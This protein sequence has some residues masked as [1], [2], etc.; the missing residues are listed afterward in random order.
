MKKNMFTKLLFVLFFFLPQW[1]MAQN[2]EYWREGFEPTHPTSPCNLATVAPTTFQSF[3]FKGN[4]GEWYGAGVYSTTGTGCPAG[5]PHLRFRNLLSAGVVDS[6]YVITP[7]VNFGIGEFHMSRARASRH[8]TLWIT[9]DTSATTTN[10]T[11]VAN[12]VSRATS[13]ICTDTTV[14]INSATARR[15]KIT[16]RP[17][18][19]TDVDSIWLT[20]F[21]R[22]VIP[23][24]LMSFSGKNTEGRNLLTWATAS[25][26]NNKGFSVERQQ[27]TGDS[28]QNIGFITANNK[29]S[30]YQFLDKNPLST[31]YYRLRQ[32]DHN[33]KETFSKTISIQT[34]GAKGKLAVYPNP[35]SNLLTVEN[36]EGSNFQ[37][38]NLLGQQ[39]LTGKTPPSGAGGLDVSALPQG[40][41]FLKVGAEQVEFV[42]Q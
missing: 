20:S 4:A 10:W 31:S 24:E 14:I 13:G 38:L 39:V 33:G 35:V 25:E 29:A 37:I 7:I 9:N 27:A 1:A 8:H 15:L 42:K 17:Q 12:L 41:Y 3:Y 30:N 40:S 23:V 32:I 11:P 2:Q 19:D 6:G 16:A 26:V 5:N 21:S 36:T 22:I 34:N 18:T 28:W